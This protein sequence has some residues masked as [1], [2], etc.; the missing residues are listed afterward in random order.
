MFRLVGLAPD[1]AT[2]LFNESYREFAVR[3]RGLWKVVGPLKVPA[4]KRTFD[5]AQQEEGKVSYMC[6]VMFNNKPLAVLQSLPTT[7]SGAAPGTPDAYY[8]QFPGVI[9]LYPVAEA[10]Q[11]VLAPADLTEGL[12]VTVAMLPLSNTKV[13][14][15]Y[16][17]E[18][19]FDE[20]LDT[21]LARAYVMPGKTWTNLKLGAFHEQRMRAGF[22]RVRDEVYRRFSI[23][24]AQWRFPARGWGDRS[25]FA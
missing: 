15:L 6:N 8:G 11:E 25:R 1:T 10:A 20:L 7:L 5:F 22:M 9:D 4:G 18:L 2:F 12:A 14:P 3:S 17:Q 23:S 19:F 16:M 21:C 24:D 13:L